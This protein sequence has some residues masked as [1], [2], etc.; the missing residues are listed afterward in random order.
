MKA[1]RLL[2]PDQIVIILGMHRSGTSCLT[3]SLQ[4]A[5][6]QLGEHSTW[7]PYNPKG[8]RENSQIMALHEDILRDNGGSWSEPPPEVRWSP[9][10]STRA[11]AILADN[12][13]NTVWGFKDPR[14][15]L[16]LQGWLDLGIK[17]NYIGIFRSP[18]AVARSL[19]A[20]SPEQMTE[21]RALALWY[22]YNI[23]LLQLQ[24]S[25]EFPL[26]CFDWDEA[27]FHSALAGATR[28]LGLTPQPVEEPFYTRELVHHTGGR[29]WLPWK[30]SSLYRTM[31]KISDRYQ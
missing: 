22:H 9:E 31:R 17:P 2:Q 28:R 30:I 24:R 15:L 16:T 12:A 8:N 5:G 29:R 13:H 27:I 7:N 26:L 18:W 1:E 11:V 19:S 3:G 14:T 6:L 20:R 4:Q 10:H 23:R 21:K 25:Y